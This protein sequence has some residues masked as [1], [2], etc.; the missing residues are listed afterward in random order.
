M[1]PPKFKNKKESSNHRNGAQNQQSYLAE[2]ENFHKFSAQLGKLGLEL[3]DI[4]GDGNCCFRALSDQMNGNENNH[5]EYRKRVCQYMRQ[6]REEFEPFVAALIYDEDEAATTTGSNNPTDGQQMG[7]NRRLFNRKLD[8]FEKY[9]RHLEQPGTY[10]DNGCLVAFARL[11]Q[12]NINIH[13]LNMPIWTINGAAVL[14]GKK[15]PAREMHL[16][17]HNGEHYSSIRPIGDKTNTPTNINFNG[18]AC[19]KSSSKTAAA[20]AKAAQ[21]AYYDEYDQTNNNT[22][23]DCGAVY[24][25]NDELNVKVEE[26]IEITKCLDINLIRDKLVENNYDSEAVINDLLLNGSGFDD[27]ETSARRGK[28]S[29]SKKKLDKKVEKKQRQMERQKLK[30]LEQR[31]K[32]MLSNAAASTSSASGG[33]ISKSNESTSSAS[34]SL[35]DPS[36]NASSSD[37]SDFNIA[38][39]SINRANI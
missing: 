32:E 36:S 33:S 25:S 37:P 13:Q 11:Y 8:A 19:A 1:K 26:I 21:F 7:P 23:E 4:T 14:M 20:I 17:Y 5:L 2:D 29:A 28:D 31:E 38:I 16:S 10:A 35:N 12:V 15:G 24:S 6:N 39:S 3:R 22:A 34:A 9:I 18:S 27:E 30:V